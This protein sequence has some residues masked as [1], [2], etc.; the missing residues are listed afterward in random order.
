MTDREMASRPQRVMFC[1]SHLSNKKLAENV[2]WRGIIEYR[3]S[4][5]RGFVPSNLHTSVGA[6][7][8]VSVCSCFSHSLAIQ[9]GMSHIQA[10]CF[11]LQ[12]RPAEWRTRVS[13]LSSSAASLLQTIAS[14]SPLGLPECIRSVTL[15]PT[16]CTLTHPCR[17][18]SRRAHSQSLGHRLSAAWFRRPLPSHT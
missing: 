8:T 14:S 1:A 7:P 18:E 5:C 4:L 12:L 2:S 10:L 15:Y 17:T 6:K 13:K 11:T 9:R 16:Y 3:R